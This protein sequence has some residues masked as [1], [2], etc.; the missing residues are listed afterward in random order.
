MMFTQ[1]FTIESSALNLMKEKEK[2][3]ITQFRKSDETLLRKLIAIGIMP[4][5]SITLE[6][7]IPSYVVKVEGTRIALDRSIAKAIYVR[8]TK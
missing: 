6:Q 4:G 1:T 7:K 8:K 3:V 2:G 5:L